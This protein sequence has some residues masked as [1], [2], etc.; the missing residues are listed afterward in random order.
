MF[1]FT[2]VVIAPSM[3]SGIPTTKPKE[4]TSTDVTVELSTDAF[5][6]SENNETITTTI[7]ETVATLSSIRKAIKLGVKTVYASAT[8]VGDEIKK[9]GKLIL[10]SLITILNSSRLIPSFI[11][12][13]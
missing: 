4:D 5:V 11:F 1:L 9:I 10:A 8:K 13:W 3:I 7:P 12:K 2:F 6:A